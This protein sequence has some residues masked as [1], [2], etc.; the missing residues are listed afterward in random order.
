MNLNIDQLNMELPYRLG[1][2]RHAILQQLRVELMRFQW[3]MGS[4]SS[5]EVPPL[6]LSSKQTNIAIAKQIATQIHRA[7]LK[8]SQRIN[9]NGS[10]LGGRS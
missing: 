4:W 5:L 9:S 10:I 2:R 6:Q 7:A 8:Q 1:S 3:P